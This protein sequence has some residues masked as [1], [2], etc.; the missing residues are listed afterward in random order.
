MLDIQAYDPGRF[1]YLMELPF[2]HDLWE[3]LADDARVRR[4]LSAAD[5]GNPA[6][7]PLL[8][9]IE[10]EFGN[11]LS[12]SDFPHEEIA[13]F[14]NNVIKHILETSG[15]DFIACTRCRTGRYIKSSGLFRKRA[16]V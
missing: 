7:E 13:V 6:I 1:A 4:M 16:P 14:I 2:A 9:D 15:Y 5:A 12:S 11:L 3:F 8:A 10:S